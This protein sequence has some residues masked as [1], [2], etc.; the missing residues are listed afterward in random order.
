MNKELY[1]ECVKDYFLGNYGKYNNTKRG[2]VLICDRL[3]IHESH[4]MMNV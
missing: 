1:E 4:S 2:D 3:Q